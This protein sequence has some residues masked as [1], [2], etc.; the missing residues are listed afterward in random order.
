MSETAPP[1]EL[2]CS[3]LRNG[4]YIPGSCSDGRKLA[5]AL[6]SGGMAGI[7]PLGEL[8][9]LKEFGTFKVVDCW[10]GDSIG[11][12]NAGIC[13]ADQIEDASETFYQMK[14]QRFIDPLRALRIGGRAIDMKILQ[15][16]I[17]PILNTKKIANSPVPVNIGITKLKPY[18]RM[19]VDLSAVE[20]EEVIPWMMR[21]AHLPIAGGAAPRDSAG[22]PYADP[23]LSSL[24]PIH[25]AVQDGCTDIIYL[26][27]QP[28]AADRKQAWQVG[29]V[30][31]WG[32]RHD[33]GAVFKYNRVVDDQIKLREAYREGPF[34]YQGANVV[35]FYPPM[36]KDTNE[37]WPTLYTTDPGRLRSGFERAAEYMKNCLHTLMPEPE[38]VP[39]IP[40]AA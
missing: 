26:S 31:A 4:N 3:R 28:Y 12:I 18:S 10:L 36:P 2:T 33:I 16:S 37:T 34:N 9:S 24:G 11:G 22:I 21:G 13:V 14:K 15:E 39:V 19:S 25:R 23:G 5:I 27:C 7:T 1:I 35:G 17:E 29:L 6:G 38:P 40:I 20:P 30:G 32:L 8:L